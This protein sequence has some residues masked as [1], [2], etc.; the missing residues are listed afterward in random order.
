MSEKVPGFEH[1]DMREVINSLDAEYTSLEGGYQNGAAKRERD[2]KLYAMKPYGDEIVGRSKTVDSTIFDKIEWLTPNI[3]RPFTEG[4]DVIS[5]EPEDIDSVVG[6]SYMSE[7]LDYQIK[8]SQ[9]WYDIVHTSVK[10]ALIYGNSYAKLHFEKREGSLPD[11]VRIEPIH[12]SEIRFDWDCDDFYSSSVVIHDV[13]LTKS[14][15]LKLK[16]KK[17]Y[18]D[19]G[20][21][22]LI[23]ASGSDYKYM[24]VNGSEHQERA[25]SRVYLGSGASQSNEENKYYIL[26]EH[27]CN[28]DVD[29]SGKSVPI[30]ATY[31]NGVL[32]R[33]ERNPFPDKKPPIVVFQAV[34]EPFSPVGWS[35]ADIL[36]DIQHTRTCIKRDIED[37]LSSQANGMWGADGSKI[38]QNGIR[39]L[40]NGIAGSVI[41]TDGDPNR[42]VHSLSPTPMAN[43]AFNYLA[44]LSAEADMKSGYTKSATMDSKMLGAKA[45]SAE[46]VFNSGQ[47]RIWEMAQRML[48]T[49]FKPMIR[50]AIAYNQKWLSDS[51]L[52]LMFGDSAGKWMMLNKDDIGGKLNASLKISLASDKQ[53][54]IGIYTQMFQLASQQ[55]ATMPKAAKMAEY[56]FTKLFDLMGA[57]EA[58]FYLEDETDVGGTGG[59]LVPGGLEEEARAA[60]SGTD[61]LDV[62]SLEGITP[63][64]GFGGMDAGN[65]GLALDESG[66]GAASFGGTI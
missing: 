17:G 40:R 48:E 39:L 16:G 23:S 24:N 13:S 28:T 1:L 11:I 54:Q 32:I 15:V 21:D 64:E 8:R 45:T 34:K 44:Q 9:S 5:V 50:K 30:I 43:H 14:D 42:A 59:A 51:Q 20:I 19:E 4:D 22:K 26:H 46:I 12:P 18:I 6:A 62:I 49:G 33:F 61:A 10:G 58:R 63:L 37:N 25:N 36:Y 2:Y 31:S 53:E 7:I 56:A 52:K 47:M 35:M 27:Y 3:V 38:S 55:A 65:Q 66:V 57:K 29:S 60:G 41:L